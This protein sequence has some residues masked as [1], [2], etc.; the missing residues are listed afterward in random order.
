MNEVTIAK[1]QIRQQEWTNLIR[2]QQESGLTVREWC[3]T[4]Q[5]SE[6][7]CYYRLRCIREDIVKSQSNEVVTGSFAELVQPKST[8]LETEIKNTEITE[9][10]TSIPDASI[11][12]GDFQ[13]TFSNTASP[14]LILS[15]ITALH[16]AK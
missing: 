12:Y 10:N 6:P 13:V 5:I 4:H 9:S 14:Q 7:S 3:Q 8:S 16:H 11:H 1:K 15:I 2:Q